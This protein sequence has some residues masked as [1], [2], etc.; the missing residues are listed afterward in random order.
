MLLIVNVASEC[1]FTDDHYRE[2]VDLQ[3]TYDHS[4]FNV[5]A[6]PCNQFGKQEPKKN[7]YIIKFA[8]QNYHV[9]FPMF[10]KV[11]TVGEH[12]H[13][14][15]KWLKQ[16][17]MGT[18]PSWNFC[19]YLLNQHGNVVRYASPSTSPLTFQ[20]DIKKL[21]A[22]EELKGGQLFYELEYDEENVDQHNEL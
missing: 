17:T 12:A 4:E 18:E 13:P 20:N 6:F 9:N 1:G 5:L 3:K 22:F 19:K 15:Y 2:L 8:E 14:I 7:K 10:S 21:L 16:E 11:K